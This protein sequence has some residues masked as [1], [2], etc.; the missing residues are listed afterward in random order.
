MYYDLSL[1]PQTMSETSAGTDSHSGDHDG[2]QQ[3][4][5]VISGVGMDIIDGA[6]QGGLAS[7]ELGGHMAKAG[8]NKAKWE[9]GAAK[10]HTPKSNVNKVPDVSLLQPTEATVDYS[11]AKAVS[12]VRKNVQQSIPVG[13]DRKLVINTQVDYEDAQKL[14]DKKARE[15]EMRKYKERLGPNQPFAGV[16]EVQAKE[17]VVSKNLNLSDDGVTNISNK[18]ASNPAQYDSEEAKAAAEAEI[19]GKIENDEDVHITPQNSWMSGEPGE[20]NKTLISENNGNSKLTETELESQDKA[21]GQTLENPINSSIRRSVSTKEASKN[22]VDNK[23]ITH[24]DPSVRPLAAS[25]FENW[26]DK[27]KSESKADTAGPKKY[28]S[29][30]NRA[31][32]EKAY[33]ANK[34][35]KAKK[36]EDLKPTG[37]LHKDLIKL[38][39]TIAVWNAT[40][41]VA[42]LGLTGAK[43]TLTAGWKGFT[44]AMKTAWH[45]P[46][47]IVKTGW[48]RTSTVA[49]YTF[50]VEKHSNN[51][52]GRAWSKTKSMGRW[53]VSPVATTAAVGFGV[54][55]GG[56]RGVIGAK[57]AGDKADEIKTQKAEDGT[58][59]MV[60]KKNRGG[61]LGATEAVKK[62]WEVGSKGVKSSF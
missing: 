49:D 60:G 34:P 62:T 19:R 57:A 27:Q 45:L 44:T 6:V 37:S 35:N 16:L 41:T 7:L 22:L 53:V 58:E 5:N 29:Y 52:L 31:K 61:I 26:G 38:F 8:V 23:Y 54:I 10:T 12:D 15:E 59:T 17:E 9:M 30:S 21:K 36:P 4:K 20:V 11:D 55:E 13:D 28:R 1:T 32:Y 2:G 48:E 40:K 3:A 14:R 33:G 50:N 39:A 56:L 25:R 24:K 47:N 42:E 43:T 51:K 18:I 46:R